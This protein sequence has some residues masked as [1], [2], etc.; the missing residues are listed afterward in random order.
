MGLLGSSL[1]A[2][3]A[4]ALLGKVLALRPSTSGNAT[5]VVSRG[6]LGYSPQV[7]CD[8]IPSLSRNVKRQKVARIRPRVQAMLAELITDR[9]VMGCGLVTARREPAL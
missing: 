7:V 1:V 5:G 4:T 6:A 3:F 9:A 2:V 8:R